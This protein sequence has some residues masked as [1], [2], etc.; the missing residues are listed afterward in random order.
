[1]SDSH[2]EPHGARASYLEND[3]AVIYRLDRQLRFV[4]CNAAWDRFALENGAPH[5]QRDNVIGCRLSKFVAGE[6]AAYY[7]SA[8][9]HVLSVQKPW[10]HEYACSSA[11]LVRQFAMNVYP[12]ESGLLVV[13][14]LQFQKPHTAA[15][16]LAFETSYRLPGGLILMC[17]NCRR[18]R[19]P[20]T[21]DVWDW[22]PGFVSAAL[23]GVSHGLCPPCGDMY[24]ADWI[25][26]DTLRP[27][28]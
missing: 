22:V 14:A 10:H 26:P 15:A 7:D 8:F 13:N 4:A 18:S 21:G 20:G 6:L 19:R 2:L 9:D 23:H 16:E 28:S 12:F 5:L 27:G 17:S 1:M 11:A 3:P 24:H 25:R